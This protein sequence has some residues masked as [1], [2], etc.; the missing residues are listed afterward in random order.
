MLRATLIPVGIVAL[1]WAGFASGYF[2]AR[3]NCLATADQLEACRQAV[4]MMDNSCSPHVPVRP[5]E[6]IVGPPDINGARP[7]FDCF[8]DGRGSRCCFRRFVDQQ[9]GFVSYAPLGCHAA[10]GRRG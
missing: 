2:Y 8:P 7:D 9:W 5:M 3:Q 1:V 10:C 4:T 6:P